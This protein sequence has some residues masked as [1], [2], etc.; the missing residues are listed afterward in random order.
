M[1]LRSH[2]RQRP[3]V[4]QGGNAVTQPHKAH[5]RLHG[6]AMANSCQHQAPTW[7]KRRRPHPT[8]HITK[9]ASAPTSGQTTDLSGDSPEELLMRQGR[10]GFFNKTDSTDVAGR[11]ARASPLEGKNN[12]STE[13]REGS[14]PATDGRCRHARGQSGLPQASRRRQVGEKAG[15]SPEEAQV[16]TSQPRRQEKNANQGHGHPGQTEGAAPAMPRAGKRQSRGIQEC[17]GTP[18]VRCRRSLTTVACRPRS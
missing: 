10:S 11:P 1:P 5:T 3:H 13:L 14:V 18:R 15:T 8:A 4:Q 12:A 17:K 9:E 16:L 7:N 2:G 6:R